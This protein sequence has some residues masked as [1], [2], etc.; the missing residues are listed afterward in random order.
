LLKVVFL[1]RATGKG[2]RFVGFVRG[3]GQKRGAVAISQ[4]WDCSGVLAIGAEDRDL[5]LAVNRL[6]EIQGGIVLTV[7]GRVE[8]EIP[9]AIG[10]YVS[11]MPIEEIARNMRR[12]QEAMAGLGSTLENAF[13]TMCTLA[14]PAIPFIRIIEKGYRRFREDDIVGV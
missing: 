3:W 8:M 1:E 6:I 12:F 14:S 5:V 7:E 2:E 13:L 4:C 10:G 11:E 9:F